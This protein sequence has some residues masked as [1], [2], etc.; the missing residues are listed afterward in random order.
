[1][2]L[3]QH[4]RSTLVPQPLEALPSLNGHVMRLDVK[5]L[6]AVCHGIL[7]QGSVVSLAQEVSTVHESAADS[8]ALNGLIIEVNLIFLDC[9]VDHTLGLPLLHFYLCLIK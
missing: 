2:G 3:S 7:T 8:E 4:Q 5:A 6:V 9:P 1:M